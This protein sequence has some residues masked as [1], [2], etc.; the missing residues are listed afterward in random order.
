M[1]YPPANFSLM[2]FAGYEVEKKQ[3]SRTVAMQ[4][5]DEIAGL[6]KV[7]TPKSLRT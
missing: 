7:K 1:Q 3:F 5:A 2:R 6:G 4:N